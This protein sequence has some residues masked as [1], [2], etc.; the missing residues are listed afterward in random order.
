MIYVS[1]SINE[2]TYVALINFNNGDQVKSSIVAIGA[3]RFTL[4]IPSSLAVAEEYISL[5]AKT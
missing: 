1:S 4:S 2:C 3:L 5:V